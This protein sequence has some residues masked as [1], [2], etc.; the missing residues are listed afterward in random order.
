[1]NFLKKSSKNIYL[2]LFDRNLNNQ[3]EKLLFNEY[4]NDIYLFK[5]KEKKKKLVLLNKNNSIEKQIEVFYPNE[6]DSNPKC[7]LL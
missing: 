1:M 7:I 2:I 4:D 5:L 3:Y 6:I